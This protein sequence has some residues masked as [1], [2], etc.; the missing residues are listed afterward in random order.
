MGDYSTLDDSAD[1]VS[2]VCC[3]CNHWLRQSRQCKAFDGPIPLDIWNRRG[4][5]HHMHPYAGD[6][7][8]R[9]EWTDRLPAPHKLHESLYP[10][11]L[12]WLEA[13][14]HGPR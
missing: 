9:F 10:L 4:R 7:G 13:T 12:E 5:N 8:L 2:L 1:G 6:H 14:E 11:W 3:V